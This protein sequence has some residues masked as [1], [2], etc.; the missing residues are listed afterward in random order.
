M[1]CKAFENDVYKINWESEKITSTLKFK[2]APK[3]QKVYINVQ[4]YASSSLVC[5]EYNKR[6]I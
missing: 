1:T 2:L 5:T 4:K 6:N 3:Y